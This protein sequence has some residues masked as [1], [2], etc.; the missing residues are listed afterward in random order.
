MPWD[1]CE[2]WVGELG[3]EGRIIASQLIAGGETESI[4]QPQWSPAGVLHF[5]SD[6][7]GWWNLYRLSEGNIEPLCKKEVE[8][9]SPQWVFRMSTYAFESEHRIISAYCKNGVWKLASID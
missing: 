6:R 2:L 4:F 7:T 3:E 5:V 1:G 9:G 8:F